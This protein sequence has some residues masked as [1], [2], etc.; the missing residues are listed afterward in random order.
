MFYAIHNS[1]QVI[2]NRGV[3]YDTSGAMKHHNV[4]MH[5]GIERISRSISAAIHC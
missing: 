5:F 1:N 2:W 4:H 3:Y